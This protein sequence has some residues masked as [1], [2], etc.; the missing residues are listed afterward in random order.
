MKAQGEKDDKYISEQTDNKK[1]AT[2]TTTTTR[3]R[4]KNKEKRKQRRKRKK[5]KKGGGRKR[6]NKIK[7]DRKTI[8]RAST[9]ASKCTEILMSKSICIM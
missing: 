3:E 8:T 5:K 2:T 9:K 7:N 6:G 1:A 4:E